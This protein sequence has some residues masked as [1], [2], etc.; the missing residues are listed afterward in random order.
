MKA[1]RAWWLTAVLT[2][3]AGTGIAVTELRVEVDPDRRAA[4]RGGRVAREQ[5]Q[6][7]GAAK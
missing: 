4:L 2:S 5:L 6:R 3:L 7:K 1:T